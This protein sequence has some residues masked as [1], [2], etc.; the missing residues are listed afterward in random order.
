M[1]VIRFAQPRTNQPGRWIAELAA[2]LVVIT[3]VL[4]ITPA[5]ANEAPL[6][7][8]LSALFT[9]HSA[10]AEDRFL[11]SAYLWGAMGEFAVTNAHVVGNATEVRLTDVDGHAE[12]GVV[13][14]TDPVRDVAVIAVAPG[15][16]GLVPSVG[17]PGLGTEVWALGAPL[18]IEFTVTRGMISARARQIEAAVPI[19][20]VQHDAAVN[21]GSS[22][23][24][25]IDAAGALI[26]MNSQIADGSR[27]F[28]GIAYAISAPDLTRIVA[29]LIDETLSPVPKLGMTARPVDLQLAAA[30]GVPAT[31]LLVDSVVPGGILAAAGVVPGDI[32]VA[33]NHTPLGELGD[34][35]FAVE[36]AGDGAIATVLRSGQA[37]QIAVAFR[38]VQ[39]DAALS[40]R[41]LADAHPHHITQYSLQTLGMTLTDTG[42]VAELTENSVALL[43]GV[44][45]G[46]R[47]ELVNGQVLAVPAMRDMVISGPIL[48]LVKGGNDLTR[49]V[50]IDPFGF[51]KGFRPVGGANVLD[52]NVVVF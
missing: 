14:A 48:L 6:E 49:H 23:G 32:V 46:D 37:L 44:V 8:A 11:G 13:T 19:R 1:S 22:G 26:G 29:G 10:D 12:I 16:R 30:L 42:V 43:D 36:A 40:M 28:V 15:R 51:R 9:V 34:L 4:A 25:L 27:M 39:Q 17:V 52:P 18:G 47:I 5:K 24:P 45:I 7:A 38:D 41:D 2:A 21:P 31:G 33:I 50:L 3:T 20:M 35:A